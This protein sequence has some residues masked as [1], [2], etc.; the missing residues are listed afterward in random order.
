MSEPQTLYL[1]WHGDD[2]SKETPD[3]KLLGVYSSERAALER[4][5]R[6]ATPPGF[7]EHPD[8]FRISPYFIDKDEW[9]AGYI[10]VG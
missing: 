4:I 6:C 8:D 10:E 1:L 5:N 9:T 7:G 2:L 3:S